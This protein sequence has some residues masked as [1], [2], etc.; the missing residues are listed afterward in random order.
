MLDYYLKINPAGRKRLIHSLGEKGI[1]DERIL[2]AIN[3]IPRELFLDET[4]YEVAYNDTAL[5]IAQKQTISQPFTVAFMTELLDIH[6]GDTVLEIGTGSGY[7]SMILLELGAQLF[8]IERI[9]ELFETSRKLF[10]T[11]H[12]NV[13]IQLADGSNGWAEYQPYDGIIVT[14]A[15]PKIPD[16]LIKQL[17]IGGRLVAPVGTIDTQTMT[18]IVRKS[19]ERIIVSEHNKFKFVP[20]I[21]DKGWAERDRK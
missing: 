9:P 13:T 18:K 5:P 17:K 12:L 10:E 21:G 2:D 8:T 3:K 4:L 14:A 7:Q 16:T 15:I 20:L 19:E 11:L 1:A 6:N